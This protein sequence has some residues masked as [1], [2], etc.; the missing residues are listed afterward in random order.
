MKRA[1]QLIAQQISTYNKIKREREERA[2]NQQQQL[3]PTEDN[4]L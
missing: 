3:A 1:D 4:L 2:H